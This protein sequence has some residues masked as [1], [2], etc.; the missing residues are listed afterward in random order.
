MCV[1]DMTPK[2]T[3]TEDR[4]MLALLKTIGI[5]DAETFKTLL[6]GLK[7]ILATQDSMKSKLGDLLPEPLV[8]KRGKSGG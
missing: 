8:P 7:A 5:K 1:E 2:E 4:E 6:K 3:S